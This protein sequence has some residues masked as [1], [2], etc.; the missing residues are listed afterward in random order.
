M[1]IYEED[2]VVWEDDPTVYDLDW[3]L[4]SFCPRH[5]A[6]EHGKCQFG[7]HKSLV[8]VYTV[9]RRKPH[10]TCPET[11]E[12]GL[13]CAEKLIPGLREK[14]REYEREKKKFQ[15]RESWCS[16][17]PGNLFL[18]R[19]GFAFTISQVTNG[20][21]WFIQGDV[22]EEG[23]KVHPTFEEAR[24]ELFDHLAVQGRLLDVPENLFVGI[25]LR[26]VLE[27]IEKLRCNWAQK[28]VNTR[29]GAWLQE[30][31]QIG[32][33]ACYIDRRLDGC[34]CRVV[35]PDTGG[36][37]DG[38]KI[39]ESK[40]A[41]M[42]EAKIAALETLLCESISFAYRYVGFKAGA[43]IPTISYGEWQP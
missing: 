39:I 14:M 13:D 32:Q 7:K 23:L 40:H 5:H 9:K 29:Q 16:T 24:D 30:N 43:L 10:P 33:V 34:L 20:W 36:D 21:R 8:Y 41:N 18:N 6:D 12:V 27:T 17:V 3:Y 28:F 38:D 26:S 37:T 19:Y 15:K 2:E 42:V 25:A 31:I 11:L 1:P 22:P 35:V 4:L